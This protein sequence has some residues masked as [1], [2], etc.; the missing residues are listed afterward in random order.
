MRG[1]ADR[2][3]DDLV[4]DDGHD[5][6][7]LGARGEDIREPVHGLGVGSEHLL[8]EPQYAV[9][10][11]GV[12]VADA[13]TGHDSPLDPCTEAVISD[14]CAAGTIVLRHAAASKRP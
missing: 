8:P 4:S 7:V 12:I 11:V 10:I 5:R 2:R 1:A 14:H 9:D 6:M 13:P 3:A